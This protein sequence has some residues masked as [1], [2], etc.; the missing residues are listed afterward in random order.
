MIPATQNTRVPPLGI[1]SQ[2]GPHLILSLLI[3]HRVTI[4]IS[5]F[6]SYTQ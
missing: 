6:I 1:S 2:E 4:H 5:F 3:N